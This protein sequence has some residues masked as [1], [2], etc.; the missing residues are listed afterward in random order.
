MMSIP[1]QVGIIP[2]RWKQIMDIMLE[3]TLG[4]SRCH[5]LW[6]IALFESDLNHAK[7]ILIGRQLS[8]LLED[9]QMLN[10]MQFRSR[11]G[12]RC[13]SAVL[14]KILCH[15]YIRLL[16]KTAAYIENDAVGCYNQLVH[17]LILMVLKKLGLP[18]SVSTCLGIL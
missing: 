12:K 11:P 6:I 9:K 8:H 3:K 16:K 1:F 10:D 4:D 7:R 5:R 14:K 17:N 15:D 13:I 18:T 2:D